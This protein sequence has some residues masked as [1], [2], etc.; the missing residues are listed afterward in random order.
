MT[1]LVPYNSKI[2][3]SQIFRFVVLSW[4][5]HLPILLKLGTKYTNIFCILNTKILIFWSK[6]TVS[7]LNVMKLCIILYQLALNLLILM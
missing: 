4:P 3:R 5:P 6:T 7:L 2:I 1:F